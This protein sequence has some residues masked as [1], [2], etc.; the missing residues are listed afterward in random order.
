MRGVIVG[1]TNGPARVLVVLT[2]SRITR[3]FDFYDVALP[4]IDRRCPDR[5]GRPIGRTWLIASMFEWRRL[6]AMAVIGRDVA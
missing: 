4:V 2:V 6:G 3:I 1:A 5:S